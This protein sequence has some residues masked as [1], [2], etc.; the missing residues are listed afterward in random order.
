MSER[1]AGLQ[2][3]VSDIFAGAPMPEEVRLACPQTGEQA[4]PAPS[5]KPQAG[6]AQ[7]APAHP[8]PHLEANEPAEELVEAAC[9]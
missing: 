1:R 7:A 9:P 5:D 3:S 8:Q 4:P 6:Q 2:K